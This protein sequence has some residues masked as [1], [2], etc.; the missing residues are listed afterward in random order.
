MQKAPHSGPWLQPLEWKGGQQTCTR[1]TALPEVLGLID[2]IGET[3]PNGKGISKDP[4]HVSGSLLALYNRV[5]LYERVWAMPLQR[6]AEEFG[7]S[8]FKLCEICKIIDIPTPR[9]GY[10]QKRA[11]NKPVP[12]KPLLTEIRIR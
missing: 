7:M 3:E 11:A 10:W 1:Q 4:L 9:E 2:P 6:V 5:E 12:V 8:S